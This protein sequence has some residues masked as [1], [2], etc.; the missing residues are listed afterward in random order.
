MSARPHPSAWWLVLAAVSPAIAGAQA[1]P[2]T[3]V[4]IPRIA[5]APKLEDYLPGGARPGLEVT[6]FRQREPKDLEA[7]TQ[8]TAAYLSYDAANVHVAFVCTQPR[9]DVRARLQK[10]EDLGSDDVV[11]VYLD[12]FHDKQRSYFFFSSP[13]GIQG[14][15]IISE[16]GGEDFSFDTQWHSDGR[17]TADGYVVL[18][19]VPFKA[20][21]FP[22]KAAGSQE[23]GISLVRSI[24]SNSE[25]D[26]WPG[27]TQRVNGFIAQFATAD[28]IAD[29]SSGRNIQ[30]VPYGTFT[31]ARFLDRDA[32]AYAR[33]NEGRAGLD[34]KLVPRD[35]V[36]LDFT[37]KPRLQPGRVRR[38]AGHRQPA[39]RS[40]L[41]R[42]ATLLP[43]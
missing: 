23:W 36:T 19:T 39:L 20:L 12:T 3:H 42:E 17:L 28:G 2:P 9:D 5:V 27:N 4:T 25:T 1:L 11:G 31:G 29:V 7:P 14:D 24:R 15:G 21:R 40:L 8:P 30:L 13:I 22:A 10:R 43:R 26:Y 18:I 33:K 37:L 32:G 41:P 38:A 35:A 6:D 16:T 34:L